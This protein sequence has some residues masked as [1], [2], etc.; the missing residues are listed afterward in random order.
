MR[1]K[2]NSWYQSKQY[3]KS[4]ENLVISVQP[5]IALFGICLAKALDIAVPFQ[6][7]A[8]EVG[9]MYHGIYNTHVAS[10]FSIYIAD[11]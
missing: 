10:L 4:N 3:A 6:V 1:H 9:T 7:T 8:K 11:Y 5:M 2:E